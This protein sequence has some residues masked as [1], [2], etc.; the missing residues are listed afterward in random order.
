VEVKSHGRSVAFWVLVEDVDGETILHAEYLL[1]K[2]RF[3]GEGHVV[4]FTIGIFEPS[5][6]QY[7]IRMGSD[8]WIGSETMLRVNF[9]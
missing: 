1:Y 9:R 6:L 3:R 8:R 2:H 5:P 4:K 7:F